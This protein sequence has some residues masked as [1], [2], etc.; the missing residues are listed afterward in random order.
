MT[1]PTTEQLKSSLEQLVE[2]Y[3]EAVRTQQNCKEAIIAT[4]AVLKDRELKDGDSNTVTS[5]IAED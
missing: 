2:T 4:Q 3:N 5:E 1:R